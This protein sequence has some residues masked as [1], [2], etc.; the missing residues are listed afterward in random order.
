MTK[1]YF[2]TLSNERFIYVLSDVEKINKA[3]F[4]K[5]KFQEKIESFFVAENE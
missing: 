1:V 4:Y 2:S 5:V 3:G